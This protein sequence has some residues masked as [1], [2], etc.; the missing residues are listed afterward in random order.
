MHSL[1]SLEPRI[2]NAVAQ[3]TSRTTIDQFTSGKQ[4]AVND[5]SDEQGGTDGNKHVGR[6]RGLVQIEARH[7]TSLKVDS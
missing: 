2:E 1:A 5:A 4:A 3:T 7:F 6:R